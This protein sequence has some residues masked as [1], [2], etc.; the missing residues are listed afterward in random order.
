MIPNS[1]D[2]P[3]YLNSDSDEEDEDVVEVEQEHDAMSFKKIAKYII[4]PDTVEEFIYEGHFI[5][6]LQKARQHKKFLTCFIYS[7][8]NKNSLNYCTEVFTNTIILTTL[9]ES[10]SFI[11]WLG[12]MN[13]AAHMQSLYNMANRNPA[14]KTIIPENMNDLPYTATMCYNNQSVTLLDVIK[15]CQDMEVV[16]LQLLNCIQMYASMLNETKRAPPSDVMSDDKEHTTIRRQQDA[17]FEASLLEDQ[18][19]QAAKAEE[20]E[21]RRQEAILDQLKQQQQQEKAIE[22]EKSAE[23]IRETFNN[24]VIDKEHAVQVRFRLPSGKTTQ[25]SFHIHDE[26]KWLFHY[27]FAFEKLPLNSFMFVSN[28]PRKEIHF[29]QHH[30]RLSD[31]FPSAKQLSLFVER[32]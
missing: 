30:T 10:K 2:N 3:I 19:R 11:F 18:K 14:I 22:M 20:E 31:A 9:H 28:F 24:R 8:D 23:S 6:A 12:N 21:Q 17:L 32:L 13:N 16:Y 29:A 7:T 15:G 1:Q 4:D 5:D 26:V 25:S 27:I